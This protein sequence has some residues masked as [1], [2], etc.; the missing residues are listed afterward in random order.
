MIIFNIM[1]KPMVIKS[2][3]TVAEI[4]MEA[5]QRL[6]ERRKDNAR[7]EAYL[8]GKPRRLK[9]EPNDVVCTKAINRQPRYF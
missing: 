2:P 6:H 4:N 7:E 9:E 8:Y 3:S 1:K 5:Q